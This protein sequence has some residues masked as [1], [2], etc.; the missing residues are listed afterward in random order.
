VHVSELSDKYV[1]NPTD[2]VNVNQRVTVTVLTV[3]PERK[4][5]SLSMKS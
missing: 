3:D 2:V 1:K 4:R 5:I